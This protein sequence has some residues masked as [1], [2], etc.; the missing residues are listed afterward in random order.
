MTCGK[1]EAG[2]L[3]CALY[4]KHGVWHH[5]N[6]K[7]IRSNPGPQIFRCLKKIETI[8]YDELLSK[9]ELGR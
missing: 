8:L 3:L 6:M 5:G 7:V 9:S 4:S 2:D 1:E